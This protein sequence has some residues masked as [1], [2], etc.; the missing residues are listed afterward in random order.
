MPQ[1]QQHGFSLDLPL[2][3]SSSNLTIWQN[4]ISFFSLQKVNIVDIFQMKTKV[5]FKERSMYFM[6]GGAF[7]RRTLRTVIT[8][9]IIKGSTF[10]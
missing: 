8:A 2:I 1:E 6:C 7:L 9:C 5:G 4:P 10:N 3:T